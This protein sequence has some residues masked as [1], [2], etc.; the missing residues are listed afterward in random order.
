MFLSVITA[1]VCNGKYFGDKIREAK[2]DIT[3]Y[4]NASSSTTSLGA[5]FEMWKISGR[6]FAEHPFLG[7]GIGGWEKAYKDAMARRKAHAYL[8]QFNQSHSIYLE[9]MNTRGLLGLISLL[10]LTACP[11]YFAMKNK[12][13]ELL[14]FRNVVIFATF[15]FLISGLTETLVRIR[16]VLMSY[17]LVTGLGLAEL[18]RFSKNKDLNRVG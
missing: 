12:E 8:M 4:G 14:F 6:L 17:N 15:A 2:D 1:V 16:F 11:V 3:A 5:R 18:I 9:A 10:L 7:I 13:S